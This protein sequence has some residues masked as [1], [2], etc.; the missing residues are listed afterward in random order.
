[1]N[2]EYEIKVLDIDKEAVIAQIEQLG[3]EHVADYNFRRYIFHTVPFDAASW[4]RLRTDGTTATLAFKSSQ[5]DAIDGMQEVEVDVSDFDKTQILLAQ[6][7]LEQSSYQ[8]NRRSLYRLGDVELAL[9]EWPHIPCYL[10]IEG[11]SQ[12]AVEQVLQ[13]L[14]LTGSQTSS[15][16]TGDIYKHYG[17]NIKDYNPLQF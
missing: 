2:T 16:P 12:E 7:G 3:G 9:D 1:M 13:S 14:E 10:E 8:E 15:L 6:A 4:V 17:K 5:A 11:S